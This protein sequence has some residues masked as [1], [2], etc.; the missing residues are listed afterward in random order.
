MALLQS[1]MAT[2]NHF[3]RQAVKDA[4][5]PSKPGFS[6]DDA[7]TALVCQTPRPSL[8]LTQPPSPLHFIPCALLL[9]VNQIVCLSSRTPHLLDCRLLKIRCTD[10]L[11]QSKNTSMKQ[12]LH[13]KAYLAWKHGEGGPESAAGCRSK[14]EWGQEHTA[15]P[16]LPA[17]TAPVQ[18]QT[19]QW[20]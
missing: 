4:S 1:I 12:K 13:K 14:L 9:F 2:N 11:H 6:F 16:C 18:F 20:T 5:S 17:L 10:M 15:S 8:S 7:V 19:M 3:H